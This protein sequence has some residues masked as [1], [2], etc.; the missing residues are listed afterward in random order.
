MNGVLLT[1]KSQTQKTT[2][3]HGTIDATDKNS[4]IPTFHQDSFGKIKIKI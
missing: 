4:I 3:D 1:G 2:Q